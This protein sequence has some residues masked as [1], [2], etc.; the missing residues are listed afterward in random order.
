MTE[1]ITTR[2]DNAGLNSIKTLW[3]LSVSGPEVMLA[4]GAGSSG[5]KGDGGPDNETLPRARYVELSHD[6]IGMTAASK[7]FKVVFFIFVYS[8][9]ISALNGYSDQIIAAF[10]NSHRLTVNPFEIDEGCVTHLDWIARQDNVMYGEVKFT[11]LQFEYVYSRPR[12]VP[13]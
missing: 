9:S 8:K 7:I 12:V 5:L 2:W 4:P 11:E 10:E 1:P 3:P 13:S 6:Q